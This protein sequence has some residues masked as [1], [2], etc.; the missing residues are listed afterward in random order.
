MVLI[1]I[2]IVIC[3]SIVEVDAIAVDNI[4]SKISPLIHGVQSGRVHELHNF[5]LQWTT[6]LVMSA[7]SLVHFISVTPRRLSILAM[8]FLL[9]LLICT[10]MP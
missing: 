4:A 1:T 2:F 6:A 5:T 7:S 10:I 9:S 3:R 8:P